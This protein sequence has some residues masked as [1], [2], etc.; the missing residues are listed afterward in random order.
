MG[1]R[2]RS[3]TA[4]GPSRRC[5]ATRGSRRTPSVLPDADQV[6]TLRGSSGEALDR[7][8]GPRIREDVGIP[9]GRID[10]FLR[11]VERIASDAGV[12]SCVYGHLGEGSLHPNLAIPPG[13]PRGEE[14]RRRLWDAALALGGTLS[15][16]HGI[17]L[18]KAEAW[19][20]AVGAPG[21]EVLRA[22][23]SACDPDGIL[24][25]GKVLPALEASRPHGSSPSAGGVP[26]TPPG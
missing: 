14:A 25:P 7:T 19:S 6:W 16:E 18:V 20:R 21:L 11:V 9:L 24:N 8:F 2:R 23:K 1:T 10:E 5:S 26:G 17:G 22:V 13:T 4:S 12:V 15:A 3:S